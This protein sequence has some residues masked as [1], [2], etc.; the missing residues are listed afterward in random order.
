M[1]NI[2]ENLLDVD[3]RWPISGDLV[4]S[5]SPDSSGAEITKNPVVRAVFMADGYRE[6]ADILVENAMADR[7]LSHRLVYPV[8]FC[9]R[10]FIELSLK[11]VISEYGHLAGEPPNSKNHEL[12]VLW[13][14]F[15]KILTYCEDGDRV[16][17]N[18]VEVVVAE[19]AKIDAGSFTFRYPTNRK[20]DPVPINMDNIDLWKLHDTME[21]VANFFTGAD[22]YLDS[23]RN[24]GP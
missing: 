1:A 23:C 8:L 2:F 15:R 24:Y 17:L 7:F 19:F 10:H 20:G 3:F 11:Y 13:P 21:G 9:Y 18:A 12:E 5:S 16:A 22:G 14:T 6:A 4:L